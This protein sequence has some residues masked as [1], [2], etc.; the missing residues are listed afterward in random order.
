M[1]STDHNDKMS[2]ITIDRLLS[3]LINLFKAK[4]YHRLRSYSSNISMSEILPKIFVYFVPLKLLELDLLFIITKNGF[5]IVQYV[6]YWQAC[7]F[8]YL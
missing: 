3:S 4:F 8:E 1:L 2:I 5:C 7:L 6:R